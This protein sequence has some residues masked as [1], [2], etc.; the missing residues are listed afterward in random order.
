M[1]GIVIAKMIGLAA[2]GLYLAIG[3]TQPTG[4]S[5]SLTYHGIGIAAFVGVAPFLS[6]ADARQAG[7]GAQ[8][9]GGGHVAY[10]APAGAVVHV[11]ARA[12]GGAHSLTSCAYQYGRWQATASTYWRD[13]YYLCTKA[14][15]AADETLD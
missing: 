3:L 4:R 7:G 12:V 15:D 5:S 2:F 8:A 10:R 1:R 14:S 6:P 13:L 11:V 9:D